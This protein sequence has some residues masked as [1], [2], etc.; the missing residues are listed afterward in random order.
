MARYYFDTDDG[1]L[2][3]V[4]DVGVSLPHDTAAQMEMQS[5]S[6]KCTVDARREG[7]QPI[8]SATAAFEMTWGQSEA[9][10]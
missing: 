10:S 8:G 2:A 6:A 5:G 7:N 9:E 4:D 3:L 1:T